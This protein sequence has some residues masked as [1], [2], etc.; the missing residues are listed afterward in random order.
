MMLAAPELFPSNSPEDQLWD[1][2]YDII[3]IQE[4][5]ES[6]FKLVQCV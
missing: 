2:L 3:H 5:V 1:V 4:K 6:L